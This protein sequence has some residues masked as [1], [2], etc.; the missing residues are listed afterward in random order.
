MHIVVLATYLYNLVP[1]KVK[2]LSTKRLAHDIHFDKTMP[3]Y[4]Q[5]FLEV[6][7]AFLLLHAR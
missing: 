1:N 7:N 4:F 5:F 3:G 6:K 2:I